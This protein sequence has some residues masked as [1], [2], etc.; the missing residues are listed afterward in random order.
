MKALILGLGNRNLGDDAL[1]SCLAEALEG[2]TPEGVEVKDGDDMGLGLLGWLEGYN[3]V[4]F[5]DAAADVED[6]QV[7][8]IEPEKATLEEAKDLVQDSH[9]AGPVTL[10]VLAHK[11]GLFKGK[12]YFVAFKPER[13]CFMCPPSEEGLKRALRAAELTSKVLEKEGFGKLNLEGIEGELIRTCEKS[14]PEA[15]WEG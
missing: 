11:S 10:A 2:R 9:K 8:L 4:V 14:L 1:G 12:A 7:F 3:L 6:V 13:L 15:P 5:L